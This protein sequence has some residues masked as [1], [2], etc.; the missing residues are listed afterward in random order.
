LCGG[1]VRR[2]EGGGRGARAL[3]LHAE[4]GSAE[5]AGAAW[6]RAMCGG[7]GGAAG[8]RAEGARRGAEGGGE[9]AEWRG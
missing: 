3:I 4:Q 1:C 5:S 8:G 7:R 2:G 6:V 9:R